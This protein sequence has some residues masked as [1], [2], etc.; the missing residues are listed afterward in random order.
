MAVF[1]S[2]N[3][4]WQ[5]RANVGALATPSP[6]FSQDSYAVVGARIGVSASD[7]SWILAFWGRNIFDKRAWSVLNSTTLQP[8]SIS[9]YV[10]DPQLL[11]ATATMRW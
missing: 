10:T 9:G 2:A 5:S 11:G 6:S 7:G 3:L 8:G 1:A 4:R